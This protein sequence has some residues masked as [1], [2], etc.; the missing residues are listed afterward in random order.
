[1]FMFNVMLKEMLFLLLTDCA[2]VAL[3]SDDALGKW[4]DNRVQTGRLKIELTPP[5]ADTHTHAHT[6]TP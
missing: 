1:M 4:M 5:A 3:Q 6:H 2:R